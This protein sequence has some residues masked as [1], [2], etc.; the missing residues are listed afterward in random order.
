MLRLKNKIY[1]DISYLEIFT[2][3]SPA[4]ISEQTKQKY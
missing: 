1:Q 4:S 3:E 2:P